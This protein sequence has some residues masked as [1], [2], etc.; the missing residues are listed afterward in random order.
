MDALLGF[1]S[2]DEFGFGLYRSFFIVRALGYGLLQAIRATY[3]R[4]IAYLIP[5]TFLHDHQKCHEGM[6]MSFSG[7]T[8]CI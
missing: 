3:I 6:T 5:L 2:G 7:V 8:T 1:A 4:P